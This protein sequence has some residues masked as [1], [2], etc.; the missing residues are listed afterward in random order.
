MRRTAI[1]T[2][3]DPSIRKHYG[4]VLIVEALIL[5]GLAWLAAHYR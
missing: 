4:L 3:D 5:S 2:D 1:P